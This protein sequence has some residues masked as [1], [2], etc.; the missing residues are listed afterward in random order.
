MPCYIAI[1]LALP[2]LPFSNIHGCALVILQAR[3]SAAKPLPFAIMT[4]D[5]THA[6]TQQLLEDNAY[7]GLDK[8]Q[9]GL[10]NLKRVCLCLHANI[11]Q[12]AH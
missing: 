1:S 5:D 6:R 4:S 7:F 3:S 2:V 8:S 12:C 10:S 11:S 9:V